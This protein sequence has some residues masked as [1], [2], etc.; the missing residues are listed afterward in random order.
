MEF[1]GQN[2]TIKFTVKELIH[3]PGSRIYSIEA[4]DLEGAPSAGQSVIDNASKETGRKTPFTEGAKEGDSKTGGGQTH[5]RNDLDTFSL[6][7]YKGG[8]LSGGKG[9]EWADGESRIIQGLAQINSDSG[10]EVGLVS[11]ES[12]KP[13][14]YASAGRSI[15]PYTEQASVGEIIAEEGRLID[16]AKQEGF[17]WDAAK[18]QSILAKAGDKGGGSEHDVYVFDDGDNAIV[19]RSTIQDSYGFRHRSP[20]QYLKRLEN[21]NNRFPGIQMRMIG[22]SLNARGNG[23]IW[24]A[25]PFVEGK[26]FKEEAQ[27]QKALEK[28]GWKRITSEEPVY[29]PDSK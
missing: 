22:V 2:L 9:V 6:G 15:P 13:D 16:R 1:E 17:F 8:G 27:V 10:A 3:P 14:A 19:I 26:E 29:R 24:T 20:A 7:L 4:M 18:V 25:Q 21:Y 5:S 11:R 23:V 28:R 12:E